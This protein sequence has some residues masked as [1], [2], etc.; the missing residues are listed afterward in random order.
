MAGSKLN[1]TY[2]D[3]DLNF[4]PHPVT[5]DVVKK[6]DVN[7]IKQSLSNLIATSHYEFPFEPQIGSTIHALLFENFSDVVRFAIQNEIGVLIENFEPRVQILDVFINEVP[8][9]HTLEVSLVFTI[10]NSPKPETLDINLQ[11]IR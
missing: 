2:K 9:T 3:I 11:R 5:G 1:R 4:Q 7:A 6:T 8:D 10:N